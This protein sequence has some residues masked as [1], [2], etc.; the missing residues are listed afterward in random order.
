MSD[1]INKKHIDTMEPDTYMSLSQQYI[2]KEISEAEFTEQCNRLERVQKNIRN[3][4]SHINAYV[5]GVDVSEII[6]TE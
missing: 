3:K 4:S 2:K 1:G 6:E 5:F